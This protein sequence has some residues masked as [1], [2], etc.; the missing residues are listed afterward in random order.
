MNVLDAAYNA[1]R[2]CPGGAAALA[3]RMGKSPSTLNHELAGDGSA[4]L[5]LMDAV[6]ISHFTGSHAIVQA[7]ADELGGVFIPLSVGARSDDVQGLGNAAKEFGE[8]ASR[9]ANAIADGKVTGNELRAIE[10]EALDSI[11]AITA[12]VLQA[13][14]VHDEAK[15]QHLRRVNAA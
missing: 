14:R 7:F 1:V 2:D 11:G 15:P 8:L 9:Y 12:M 4:K 10:R 13:R 6:K 3:P 5:G